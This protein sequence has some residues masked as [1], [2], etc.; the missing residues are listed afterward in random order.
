[1]SPPGRWSRDGDPTTPRDP[2][3]QDPL[4]RLSGQLRK[5]VR[6]GAAVAGLLRQAIIDGEYSD[7]DLLPKED[8]LLAAMQVS[9]QSLRD[10]MRILETEGLVTV[11]RGQA[12]GA[13][14]H[15]PKPDAAAYMLSLVLASRGTSI[16]DLALAIEAVEPIC[17]AMCAEREDRAETVLPFLAKNLEDLSGLIDE[18]ELFTSTAREF[19][20][21]IADRC[22]CATLALIIG[23]LE[24]LWSAQSSRWAA[25]VSSE[26]RYP[27]ESNRKSTLKVHAKILSAIEAGDAE[28]ARVAARRHLRSTQRFVLESQS[29]SL[30]TSLDLL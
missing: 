25:I 6:V 28:Q 14:V 27:G 21:A 20:Q 5:P 18:E 15:S 24:T 11:R 10:A 17:A 8:E 3:V 13:V 22:G 12:G 4:A 9:R 19:H 7:G 2:G 29:E 30:I 23:T 16:A 26:R 1:M